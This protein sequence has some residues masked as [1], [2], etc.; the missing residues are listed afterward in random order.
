MYDVITVGTGTQDVFIPADFL[1]NVDDPKHLKYLGFKTGI[2]Q[3]FALGSKIEIPSPYVTVGGGACNAAVTFASSGF[4][5]AALFKAGNDF[6]EKFISHF[7]RSQKV[8]PI[9]L[10]QKEGVTA[11]SFILLDKYGERT[12]L[13]SRGCS[14][15]I[16]YNEISLKKIDARCVYIA[17]GA[18]PLRTVG[19]LVNY[20][21]ASSALV[22]L[23]PSKDLIKHGMRALSSLLSKIDV[24]ILNREEAALLTKIAYTNKQALYK[25]I[26][27][28]VS[29]FV[30]I[31]DGRYG[32]TLINKNISW[33]TGVFSE[34]HVVDRTGAGDA[35]GSGFVSAL[36]H[37]LIKK[38]SFGLEGVFE[39]LTYASANA[40]SVIEHKGA[41]KGVLSLTQYKKDKRWKSLSIT[42]HH[43]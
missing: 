20:F 2:A 13:V 36:L 12:V 9:C 30:V 27:R 23:N 5:T 38:Q 25:K 22:A 34:K 43:L 31:T 32:A 39:A 14:G 24:L 10:V 18:M 35:F 8:N 40:T 37:V 29:G 16:S 17:P 11:Q 28:A 15:D 33:H 3:C 19:S 41:T 7:L 4:K 21:S 6:T 42:K 26:G 1:K